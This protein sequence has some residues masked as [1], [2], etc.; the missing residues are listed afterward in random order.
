MTLLV[1]FFAFL[2]A[3]LGCPVDMIVGSGGSAMV[4]N[5]AFISWHIFNIARAALSAAGFLLVTILGSLI[6]YSNGP[7]PH[8]A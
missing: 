4:S 6:S 3:V 2:F 8:V 5:A 1:Y 7:R